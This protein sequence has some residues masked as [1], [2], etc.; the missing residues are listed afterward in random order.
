MMLARR[1][2]GANQMFLEL[3]SQLAAGEPPGLIDA[4]LDKIEG[5]LSDIGTGYC[6]A[7]A[8]SLFR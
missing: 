5:P 2:D 7:R 6:Q 1:L 4:A 3:K 8:L